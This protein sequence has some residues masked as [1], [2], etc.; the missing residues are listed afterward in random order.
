MR[1]ERKYVQSNKRKGDQSD[2]NP[3]TADH[4]GGADDR[5]DARWPASPA[6]IELSLVELAGGP[7][8]L[9]VGQAGRSHFSLSARSCPGRA[10]TILFEAACRIH[11]AAGWLGST[12]RDDAGRVTRVIAAAPAAPATV[13]WSY[14]IGPGGLEPTVLLPPA[15]TG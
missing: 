10:E 9:G 2:Q 3:D 11:E 5:S 13:T 6:L 14:A 4:E 7:V 12:Y 15:A 8:V 1:F